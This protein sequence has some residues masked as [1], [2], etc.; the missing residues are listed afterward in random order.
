MHKRTLHHHWSKIRGLSYWSL[1]SLALLSGFVAVMAL[2][3][4][5]VTALRLRDKVT[6]ADEQNA[7][8]EAALRDLRS[9]V[10]THMNTNLASGPNA[11]RPPV[12]L[13]YRYERL[14]RT[15]KER[16]SAINQQV[17]TKAQAVCEQAIPRGTIASR[18]PCVEDYVAKNTVKEQ[19]IPDALYKFDFAPPLW[20]PDLAGWSLVL[21]AAFGLLL[22]LRIAAGFWV[23]TQLKKHS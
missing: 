16:V 12:Q 22:V 11:I 2:R 15:E 10:Y 18:V 9:Y 5:N 19:A 17:Y 21:A 7:D 4:N 1:L 6:Q 23:N 8:V 14:L 13:K 3:N 20:S